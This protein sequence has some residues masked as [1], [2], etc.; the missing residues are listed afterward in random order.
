MEGEQEFF[1]AAYHG[2]P[3][4]DIGKPQKEF[5]RLG[6]SGEIV[7]DVLDVGCGTGENA[8]FL[9]GLGPVVCGIDAAPT[10][11]EIA[12]QKARE[13]GIPVTFLVK[14]AL[15]LNQIPRKFDTVID[16]G[17]FHVLSDLERACFARN[18]A[19]VLKS[20]GRYF[21]LCFSDLEPG[22]YG[23]RRVTQG[24]IRDTFSGGWEI[25]YIRPAVFE[26]RI[27]TAGSKAWLSSIVKIDGKK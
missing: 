5:V 15:N 19:D 20:S 22:G 13:R 9:A 6:R 8:F 11:I 27:N 21:M 17:L 23:P 3:P 14:D 25:R 1:E 10:A 4:W 24:E 26:N 2:I 16:S 12:R 18:L 7:G